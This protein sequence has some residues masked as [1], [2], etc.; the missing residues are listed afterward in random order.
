MNPTEPSR[1]GPSLFFLREGE[2]MG[3]LASGKLLGGT[4]FHGMGVEGHRHHLPRLLD[5]LSPDERIKAGRFRQIADQERFVLGRAFVRALCGAQMQMPASAVVIEE[6]LTGRPHLPDG[7]LDFNVSHSGDCVLIAWSTEGQV[8]ADVEWMKDKDPN[9]L[10]GIAGASFSAEERAVFLAASAEDRGA[11]FYR[12]WVRKEAVIKAEGVGLGGP[13]QDFSVVRLESGQPVWVNHVT[14]PQSGRIWTLIDLES[15]PGY[16]AA[17]AVPQ[18]SK[19]HEGT[20][21]LLG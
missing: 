11:V 12:I 7:A 10:T 1:I 13:L 2:N 9:T 21:V 18:G 15:P 20:N 14:F 19:V 16:A 3:H 6:T 4:R 17:L 5:G 8:G